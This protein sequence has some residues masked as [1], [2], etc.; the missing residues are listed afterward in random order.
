M[1]AV[2]FSALRILV[3]DDNQNMRKI[4][5]AV[6]VGLGVRD[7]H[8]AVDGAE[9]LERFRSL[10]P[11]IVITDWVM[12]V[13]DGLELTRLIRRDPASPNPF[14]PIIVVSG[15]TERSRVLQAREAGIHE[16]VAKPVSARALYD[17]ISACVINPREFLRTKTYF[18]P[19]R[20]RFD[21]PGAVTAE[22]RAPPVPV[23]TEADPSD[24]AML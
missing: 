18:G 10:A 12:P 15:H 2:D 7:I 11:D 14:V 5:R 6:L 4:L 23:R 20:R 17:R 19:D 3:V 22:R 1:L 16:F 13:V 8:E 21:M 9:A 24:V